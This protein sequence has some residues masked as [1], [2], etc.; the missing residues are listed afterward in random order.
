[1]PVFYPT[2]ARRYWAPSGFSTSTLNYLQIME[3]AKQRMGFG[4][5]TFIVLRSAQAIL[6]KKQE[7]IKEFR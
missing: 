6:Q 4:D 1:M 3:E 2:L 5:I 7:P